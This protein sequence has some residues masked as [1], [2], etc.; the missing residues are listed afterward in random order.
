MTVGSVAGRPGALPVRRL[1]GVDLSLRCCSV[2]EAC[3]NRLH[4]G[5]KFSQFGV[6][7]SALSH[8]VG[9]YCEHEIDR[10]RV[11]NVGSRYCL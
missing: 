7:G 6:V 8:E 11:R 1:Q 4:T 5:G 3:P 10:G 9:N 2:G